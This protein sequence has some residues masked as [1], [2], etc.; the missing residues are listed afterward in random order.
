MK[1]ENN[2]N[3]DIKGKN[4]VIIGIGRSGAGAGK[5]AKFLGANVLISE[6]KSSSKNIRLSKKLQSFGIKTELGGHS[7]KI[8]NA[9]LW[10][11]S[12]G[13][14]ENI[15]IVKTA[16]KKKIEIISEIE[17]A[18]WYANAQIIAITG[19]NGKTTTVNLLFKMCD[20]KELAPILGGNI[21]T[22]F[23]DLVLNDLQNNTENRV[24][25]L[26]IS[27]FQMERIKYFKPRISIFLNITE[28]H[29]DRYKGMEDYINAKLNMIQNQD[30]NDHIVF[31]LDDEILNKKFND[32]LP[33]KHG[34]SL[35]E[36][37]KNM[38]SADS[39]KIYDEA[40]NK[41]IDLKNIRLPG[42][43][44]LS[45]ILA[46]ATAAKILGI[47]NSKI[48]DTIT[49]F[50]GV[51]HRI[52]KVLNINGVTYYNDSKATNV[53][54][55]Q[56]ALDS[57]V[58]PINLILGGKDKGGKFTSLL[59]HFKNKVK[60]IIVYGEAAS[61]IKSALGDAVKLK[62]VFSLKDAVETCHNRS[63]PGDIVLL[64]PGCASFDQFNNF[65][66]R[67]DVFKSIVKEIAKS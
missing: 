17:F 50:T 41:L 18:S 13:V 4:I 8:F 33:K 49:S 65:E 40:Y 9:D 53:E 43:H 42:K 15:S 58:N 1:I 32:T 67:G 30:K 22:A 56:V 46:A 27:S 47:P 10:I 38:F 63:K 20:V 24:Y 31:N 23:S 2:K 39:T 16:Y 28:D 37:P 3:V 7:E 29:L 12:P 34:F 26:E 52:E 59:P 36:N 11:I 62:I 21:G 57:F 45:N 35:F 60:E 44:N 55:V 66:E 14:P 5:L 48:S 6:Q 19:S 54:A 51:E 64:S 61:L 25:I